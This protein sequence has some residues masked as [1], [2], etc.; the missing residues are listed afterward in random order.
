MWSSGKVRVSRRSKL[1][2]YSKSALSEYQRYYYLKNKEAILARRK[3][4]RQDTKYKERLSQYRQTNR[5][6]ITRANSVYYSVHKE[7]ILSYKRLYR[8]ENQDKVQKYIGGKKKNYQER[9]VLEAASVRVCF[10]Q[11]QRGRLWEVFRVQSRLVASVWV[12]RN[13]LLKRRRYN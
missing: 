5:E 9:L 6:A 2:S 12:L 1:C 10:S 3:D 8:K 7:Q 4:Q 13:S 11:R